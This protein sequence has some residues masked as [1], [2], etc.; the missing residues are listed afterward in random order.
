MPAGVDQSVINTVWTAKDYITTILPS[1]TFLAL[2]VAI[3]TFLV[4]YGDIKRLAIE[5]FR[6]LKKLTRSQDLLMGA[7]AEEGSIS[8]KAYNKV[9][10]QF[11]GG[12]EDRLQA[13]I[14]RLSPSGNPFTQKDIDRFIE[15]LNAAKINPPTLSSDEAF[16]FY[17]LTQR[18]FDELLEATQ[19]GE[20]RDESGKRVPSEVVREFARIANERA[21]FVLGYATSEAK[22]DPDTVQAGS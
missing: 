2:L 3:G 8:T 13:F 18:I 20:L 15:L 6:D 17:D 14:D 19:K 21:T 5:C 1:I 11:P 4:K 10:Q 16:E 22:K 9:R 7:L 12:S